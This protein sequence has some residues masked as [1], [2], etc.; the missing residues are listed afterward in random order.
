MVGAVA[1]TDFAAGCC[2]LA[3]TGP[4]LA[5]ATPTAG[6]VTGTALSFCA[7]ADEA[8]TEGLAGPAAGTGA[9]A[10]AGVFPAPIPMPPV[11]HT[12]IGHMIAEVVHHL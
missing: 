7:A 12:R 1:E 11:L 6:A 8:T 3:V 5:A 10:A 2:L 9:V 4:P